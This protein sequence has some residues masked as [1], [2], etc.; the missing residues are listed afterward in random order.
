MNQEISALKMRIAQ[1][2]AANE[3]N[4]AQIQALML[5]LRCLLPRLPYRQE[6][7]DE[8]ERAAAQAQVQ[9][10]VLLD[11]GKHIHTRMKAHLAWLMGQQPSS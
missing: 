1:L 8:V 2:N 3:E 9:P 11:G 6:V 5:L 10:G 4:S 7:I